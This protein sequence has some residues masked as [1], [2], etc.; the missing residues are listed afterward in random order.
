MSF[1]SSTHNDYFIPFRQSIEGI[2]LP[3]KFTFPFYYEPHRLSEIAATELQ[4]YLA[5]QGVADFS[6]VEQARGR[7]FG[8]LVV[9]KPD[10]EIGYLAAFSGNIAGENKGVP[11]VPTIFDFWDEDGYYRNGERASDALTHRID[12]LEIDEKYLALKE[13][14][15]QEVAQSEAELAEMQQQLK[16]T[17]K[18]RAA[19]RSKGEAELSP[20]ALEELKE[21]LK[22]E[23]LDGQYQF[24]R[25]RQEWR[26]RLDA[27]AAEL[28][29]LQD[30]I[31]NLKLARKQN[32]N[33]LQQW[34]FQGYQFLNQAG[35]LKSL[36]AIFENTVLQKPPAGAG[37]CAAPRL[38]QY[39]F[40]HGLKLISMAEFW[41]GA[42]PPSDVREH[43]QY[44]P[45]CRGKCEPILGH[46]L[47]G[48]ELED[49]PML[50]NMGEDKAIEIIYEDEHLL[51]INK[52]SGLLSVPGKS[53]TDSVATRMQL[54][55]REATGP[56]VVHRLDMDTSGLM[57]IAKSREIHK[58]L[59]LQFIRR[60]VKK[61][62]I[63]L[64][65]GLV[66]G[67]EGTIELPLMLD[68]LDRP[69]QMVSFEEG[70]AAVT[71][72]KVIEKKDNQ[73]L[74]HFYPLTGRTHQL[75][76]HA[77]HYLGLHCPIVGDD[78][79]GTK[80]TRLHLHAEWM[81]FTHPINKEIVAF[82]KKIIF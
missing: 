66:E 32:S 8:V 18:E 62:Y 82:E 24:K 54:L 35:E 49:N 53:V 5:S 50:Q 45:A 71:D 25:T 3:E 74:I 55:F 7:M 67:E 68:F 64:L 63:A 37:D 42:T 57:L 33:A 47:Q 39:A 56:L 14:L 1:K 29:L 72:W 6:E 4:G 43:L 34:L 38:L 13:L 70:K 15:A 23:S 11:F 28:K 22:K 40:Q 65:D 78:L 19:K 60:K 36:A 12:A 59:Q 75:R 46:M 27:R 20:E 9:Q 81:E 41:W 17:K 21:E 77:A 58:L 30:K 76:M 2:A 80:G 16:I 44:Y 69:R 52:P 10:G 31:D 73:T 26:E 79:Y 61:R 48:L 51:I